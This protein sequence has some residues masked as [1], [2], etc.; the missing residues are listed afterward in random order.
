M[1]ARSLAI[2]ARLP[3]AAQAAC[4]WLARPLATSPPDPAPG[5]AL[6]QLP[7]FSYTPPPYEGPPKEEVLALRKRFLSPGGELGR[8]QPRR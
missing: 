1:R 6:P 2:A 3:A 7:P 4:P 8:T 5:G